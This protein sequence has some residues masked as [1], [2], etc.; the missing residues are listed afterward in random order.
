[1]Q[2]EFAKEALERY[3]QGRVSFHK[4]FCSSSQIVFVLSDLNVFGNVR[5]IVNNVWHCKVGDMR[6]VSAARS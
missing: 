2:P 4:C 5:A 1:M 3:R 6:K